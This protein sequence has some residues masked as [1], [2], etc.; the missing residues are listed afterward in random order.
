MWTVVKET[1]GSVFLHVK[2]APDW[3]LEKCTTFKESNLT[4]H[5]TDAFKKNLQ[6][7]VLQVN[8]SRSARSIAVSIC[9]I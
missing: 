1:N 3:V 9:E 4:K 8:A 7:N 5:I 2:G 6:Q